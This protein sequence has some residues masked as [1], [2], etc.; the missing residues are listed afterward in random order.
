MFPF[1]RFLGWALGGLFF[2]ANCA[3]TASRDPGTYAGSALPPAERSYM[4][5]VPSQSFKSPRPMVVALH[6]CVQ[7]AH[8]FSAGTKWNELA[9]REGFYVLYPNQAP[10]KNALNCWNWFLPAH[11]KTDEGELLDLYRIIY[12]ASSRY[13]VDTK[14]IYVVG[15]SAGGAMAAS[16]LSCFPRFF[17]GGAIHSGIGYGLAD[18]EASARA[19]MKTGPS[20]EAVVAGDCKPS[21]NKAPV[22]VVHGDKD[23]VVHP[24]NGE[25]ILSDFMGTQMARYESKTEKIETPDKANRLQTSYSLPGE[26]LRYRLVMVEGLDH[27]WSGGRD[28][29]EWNDSKGP[30]ATKMIWE[31]FSTA[32]L[33]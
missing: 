18:S 5:Y 10:G 22:I 23:K 17:A 2:L 31:F 3:S 26:R 32:S 12:Q 9:E 33:E 30:S 16:L 20:P 27:A 13:A 8:D 21:S 29:M 1:I 7:N 25:R 24:K 28:K 4:I 6:G 11:Q 14:K 19:L 15:M